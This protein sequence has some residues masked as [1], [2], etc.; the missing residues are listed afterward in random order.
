MKN[1]GWTPA[2]VRVSAQKSSGGT[3]NG[4]GFRLFEGVQSVFGL[5]M[6][7]L[8]LGGQLGTLQILANAFKPQSILLKFRASG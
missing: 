1:S 4:F 3:R 2:E 5:F 6:H 8:L 7:P